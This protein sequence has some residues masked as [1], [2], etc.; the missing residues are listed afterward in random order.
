MDEVPDYEVLLEKDIEQAKYWWGKAAEQ[1]HS[2]AID[3]L[4]KIYN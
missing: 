2:G 4:Q 1:G 3:A